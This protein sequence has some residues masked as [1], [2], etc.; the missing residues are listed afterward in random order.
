MNIRDRKEMLNALKTFFEKNM[1]IKETLTKIS[2]SE[3][4]ELDEETRMKYIDGLYDELKYLET[5]F[6]LSIKKFGFRQDAS[7]AIKDYF[8]KTKESILIS[9]YQPGVCRQEFTSKFSDM[10]PKLIEEVKDKFVGYTLNDGSNLIDLIE[11]SKTVNE[12]LHVIHSYIA[13]NQEILQAMPILGT[14]TIEN[15][16][17]VTLYGEENEVARKIF[18]SFP[19]EIDVGFTDI[20]SL[21]SN[22]LM[23]IRDR[24]HALSIDIDTSKK[25]GI[26]VRYFVP[27]LCNREM[28]EKLPGINKS[29]ITESGATGFFVAS[30]KKKKK[31]L[32]DF[33]Q[34]VP[35]DSNMEIRWYDIDEDN[36]Q[37]P[38]DEIPANEV[39]QVF[40][41]E[42]IKEIA[43]E[44]GTTGR[45]KVV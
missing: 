24:G 15:N 35:T 6:L 4:D 29:G 27:K 32:F 14:K 43:M 3:H 20:V 44:K 22:V 21:E 17:S 40:Y 13:N 38:E 11:K 33:I 2:P 7:D 12:L 26:D 18:D 36:I 1:K 8:N 31:K 23:M 28:V 37:I 41:Q 45:K 10:D 34:K 19:N 39:Q 5:Q 16:E 30:K 42:D 9:K 25:D